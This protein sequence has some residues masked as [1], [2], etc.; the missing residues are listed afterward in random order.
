[1]FWRSISPPFSGLKS[2]PNKRPAEEV[3]K[4]SHWAV[5]DLHGVTAKKIVLFIV[6][7]VRTWNSTCYTGL[8][9]ASPSS[10]DGK[11][12]VRLATLC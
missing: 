2:E 7:I 6:T 9:R 4:Q 12:R 1:M 11:L 5:S 10:A 3:H 8:L